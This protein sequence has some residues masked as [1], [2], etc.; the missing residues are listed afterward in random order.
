MVLLSCSPSKDNSQATGADLCFW[1][2]VQ[3][4]SGLNLCSLSILW[5]CVYLSHLQFSVKVIVAQSCPSLCDPMDCSPSRLLCPW[6]FQARI[7]E[8]VVIPFSKWS[9]QPRDWTRI[10]C[11]AGRFF[12]VWATIEAPEFSVKHW[13]QATFWPNTFTFQLYEKCKGGSLILPPGW[14][15][16]F[17]LPS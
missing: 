12:T 15:K 9:S 16:A 10:S 11:I 6:I 13:N 8:R 4:V 2:Q 3:G 1:P 5:C 17:P 14:N 7:L